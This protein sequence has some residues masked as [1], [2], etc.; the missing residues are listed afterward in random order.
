MSITMPAA[1]LGGTSTPPTVYLAG[2][3]PA[4]TET[5][6]RDDESR[7]WTAGPDGDYHDPSNRHHL[8][9]AQLHAR[10]DLVAVTQ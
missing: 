1:D 4:P 6:L 9:P 10:T 5:Q 7:V 8:S 3:G 2:I